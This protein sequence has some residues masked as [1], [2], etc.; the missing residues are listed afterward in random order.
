ML[1]FYLVNINQREFTK[2]FLYDFSDVLNYQLN[3]GWKL[4]HVMNIQ[5][6]G[7]GF[8]VEK[9]LNLGFNLV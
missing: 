7:F 5:Y 8:S 6:E 1:D 3:H 9:T 2:F 4:D